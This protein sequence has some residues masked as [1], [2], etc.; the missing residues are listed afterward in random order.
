MPPIMMFDGRQRPKGLEFP[1]CLECNNGTSQSD[2]VASLL[3]RVYPD[4]GSEQQQYEIKKLLRGVS[5]SVPGLLEEMQIGR[6]GQKF[7]QRD[8]P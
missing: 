5:N 1:I 7:A 3:G 4:S 2:Q 6:A 8:I